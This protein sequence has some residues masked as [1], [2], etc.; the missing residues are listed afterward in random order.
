[1][2]NNPD[3]SCRAFFWQDHEPWACG[4][5]T[6]KTE[7]HYCYECWS[8]VVTVGDVL[9]W[10]PRTEVGVETRW[11]LGATRVFQLTPGQMAKWLDRP[12]DGGGWLEKRQ[13]VAEAWSRGDQLHGGPWFVYLLRLTDGAM[14]VGQ[15]RNLEKRLA[16]HNG[17]R[18]ARV[19]TAN[20]PVAL[21]HQAAVSSRQ[22]AVD[23]ERL[24]RDSLRSAG[25]RVS[26][27]EDPDGAWAII[28]A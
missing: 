12:A 27:G 19:T 6:R 13:P 20:Q 8:Q 11:C 1:M 18:G 2:V 9:A 16:E 5:D 15:T 23:A 17:G 4:A 14:Y 22:A 21:V 25:L 24:L 26:M 7:Y 10:P 28:P 3:R